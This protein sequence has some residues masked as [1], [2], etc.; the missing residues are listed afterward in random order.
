MSETALKKVKDEQKYEF[1]FSDLEW[2][3]IPVKGPDGRD[4][5]LREADAG[6][7]AKYND[8]RISG[9]TLDD[10]KP[11]KVDKIGGLEV[12]LVS[13]CLK[14]VDKRPVH[15]KT[16]EGWHERVIKKLYSKAREISDLEELATDD[17]LVILKQTF[18]RENAPFPY[19]EIEK[20][21][22]SQTDP[23]YQPLQKSMAVVS[24]EDSA[25]NSLPSMT[26]NSRLQ[27]NSE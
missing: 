19:S 4:Y 5:I 27:E 26:N 21:V 12:L 24:K 8:A 15:A 13:L 22:Q 2:V 18:E 11:V 17:N 7:A 6:A 23:Y 20:F 3:E 25:K 9:I 16:L 10:G 14:A 1:D